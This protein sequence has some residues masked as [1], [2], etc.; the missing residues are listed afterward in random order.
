M[1]S[2]RYLIHQ[3][4]INQLS[5]KCC[6]GGRKPKYT[7]LRL[8]DESTVILS[9]STS[10]QNTHQCT[11]LDTVPNSFTSSATTGSQS[12]P[13]HSVMEYEQS[14]FLGGFPQW[15]ALAV[16][17]GRGPLGGAVRDC[18]RRGIKAVALF[19]KRERGSQPNRDGNGILEPVGCR[20]SL[21]RY[22]PMVRV[23]LRLHTGR[24]TGQKARLVNDGSHK[25]SDAVP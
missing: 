20:Y 2:L 15:W 7:H 4:P 19:R 3:K 14:F 16:R 6:S 18:G 10:S 24:W 12:C 21:S 11:V 13:C 23:L 8:W 9:V 17:V 22:H 5:P 1:M 25:N